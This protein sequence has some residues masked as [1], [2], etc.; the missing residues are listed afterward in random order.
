M[1]REFNLREYAQ[2]LAIEI[3]EKDKSNTTISYDIPAGILRKDSWGI[4]LNEK[5]FNEILKEKIG[6]SMI[7]G[8]DYIIN[9]QLNICLIDPCKYAEEF[10]KINNENQNITISYDVP[11]GILKKDRWGMFLNQKDL[12]EM[13]KE[14]IGKSMIKS[15]DYV[16]NMQLNLCLIDPCK[17]YYKTTGGFIDA[18]A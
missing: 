1:D 5:D 11:A 17:E 2:R 13:F 4:C 10:T 12:N 9:M 6:K 14:K 18:R 3:S 7:E 8:K 16:I 15:K